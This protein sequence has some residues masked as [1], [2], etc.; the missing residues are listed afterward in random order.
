MEMHS[1][2][3][4]NG[5][6]ESK[7]AKRNSAHRREG[8]RYAAATRDHMD[9]PRARLGLLQHSGYRVAGGKKQAGTE[10]ASG[11]KRTPTPVAR[12]F[13]KRGG[14]S[15]QLFSIRCCAYFSEA[16]SMTKRYFTSLLASLSKAWLIC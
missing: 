16:I 14:D 11:M 9:R 6:T 8:R 10:I 5:C 2:R 15:T 12:F 1:S 13:A 4:E 7:V 3:T